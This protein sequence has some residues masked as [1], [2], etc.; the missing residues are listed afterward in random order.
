[1]PND[2]KCGL[3][4]GV[5]LVLA[6]AILLF[7]PDHPAPGAAAPAGQPVASGLPSPADLPTGA[8]SDRAGTAPSTAP[9][10]GR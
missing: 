3:I 1:M 5:G 7:R 10:R 6:V 4:V 8:A 9:K 2:A